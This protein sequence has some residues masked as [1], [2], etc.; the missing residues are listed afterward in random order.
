MST[1]KNK[2]LVLLDRQNLLLS[3]SNLLYFC[4]LVVELSYNNCFFK[5]FNKA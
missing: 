4:I 2:L 3:I 1:N 5:G